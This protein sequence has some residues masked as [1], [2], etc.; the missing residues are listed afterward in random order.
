MYEREGN[1]GV[2][3]RI[4]AL[5]GNIYN[6]FVF[7]YELEMGI[8]VVASHHYFLHC[9]DLWRTASTVAIMKFFS[10]AKKGMATFG[11]TIAIIVNS[12]LLLFV[13]LIGV[14]FTSVLSRIFGKKFLDLKLGKKTYWKK[15]KKE[16]AESH[17]RQF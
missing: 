3:G 13:Y 11:Q 2:Y 7:C 8:T 1:V 12:I 5:M 14:G 6:N 17:Y 10:E 16:G 15:V 9:C 4:Y